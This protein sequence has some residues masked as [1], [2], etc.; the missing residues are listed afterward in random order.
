MLIAALIAAGGRSCRKLSGVCALLWSIG[1][2]LAVL[3]GVFAPGAEVNFALVEFS[4]IAG[5]A[6]WALAV[7]QFHCA[8]PQWTRRMAAAFMIGVIITAINGYYQYFFGFD[9]MKNFLQSQLEAGIQV[10]ESIQIKLTDTRITGFMA[11]PNALAGALLITLPLLFYFGGRWG[12]MF[13]PAKVSI[14]LFRGCGIILLGGAL[15]LCRS[16]SVFITLIFAGALAVFSAPFVKRKIK[17]IAAVAVVLLLLGG[18][19]FAL[20]YGRGFGSIAER[21]DYLRTSAVLT[22]ENPLSGAG[23]GG[24]FFRHMQMK[25]TA[26]DEAARDPHNIVAAFAGQSGVVSGIVVLAALL[27]PL[28]MLW[29][30]RFAGNWKCTVFWS[31][32]FFTLH[33]LMDCDMHIPAI[34]AGMIVIFFSAFEVSPEL[35]RKWEKVFVFILGSVIAA[36]SLWSNFRTLE[37]E[38]R[39]AQFTEFLNPSSVESRQRFAGLPMEKFESAAADVRPALALIPEFAGDWF[40]SRGDLG[41]AGMRY[42]KAMKLEPRRPGI[43]RRM[44]QLVCLQGDFERGADLLAQ[45]QQMFPRNPKYSIEHPE[46][47]MMFPADFKRRK[48]K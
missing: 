28:M 38:Y 17:I 18:A 10:P 19:C 21:A 6:A 2:L 25:F 1:L 26:T 8:A 15:I 48:E 44:A 4:N 33:I 42:L 47:R 41:S 30:E 35:P 31:G 14:V 34:M 36:V 27:L 22:L 12:K 5:I 20:K 45:A 11:S 37:G 40:L 29:K 9:V 16:R 39:L 3:P 32:L 13:E 7:W 43:Y 24:F 23:W 46:N